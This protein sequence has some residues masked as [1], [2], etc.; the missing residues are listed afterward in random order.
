MTKNTKLS[1]VNN[2]NSKFIFNKLCNAL[3]NKKML[4]A[5][6]LSISFSFVVNA[7]TT[8]A[9][10][11]LKPVTENGS[12]IIEFPGP[13]PS[14]INKPEK[15]A[16]LPVEI[17]P[18]LDYIKNKYLDVAY[19]SVSPTQTLDIYLPNESKGPF[20]VI[21]DIHGGAFLLKAMTSKGSHELEIVDAG[22]KRGYAVISINYRLSG[23]ARFPRAVNDAKAAIRF[24]R[25]NAQKYNFNPN[26]IV[27]WGGSAGGNL[28]ALLG[29]TENVK[30]LDGDNTENLQY[31]SAVQAVVDWFGPCDFLKYDD[32]FK[33]SGKH[34]PFGSVFDNNSGE[35]LYIGQ[36]LIKD[37]A[38]TEKANPETYIPTMN[39]K[40][41]P[42]FIIQH[43]TDDLNIPTQ[44]SI[45]LAKKLKTKLGN[46]QVYL[47]LLK[48]A[49]HGDPAFSTQSN[50]NKVF[51][52]LDKALK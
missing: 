47:E 6:I 35:T 24:V 22:V 42:F 19:G 23:E 40:K 48:G 33:A 30:N 27:A 49:H 18:N 12:G 4:A 39:V 51:N 36:S 2:E 52:L 1:D 14:A 11:Q 41:A 43:G 7:Q 16:T 44:Q 31:S 29:T 8:N 9:I 17:V 3:I 5:V 50:F 25:A 20:P 34:T 10:P 45:N 46:K 15:D 26:K 32:Q 21:V 28:V 37:K 38:F 13:P